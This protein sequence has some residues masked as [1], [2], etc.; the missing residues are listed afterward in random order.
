MLT[1]NTVD[2]IKS[3]PK[4]ELH[5]FQIRSIEERLKNQE[6]SED[7]ALNQAE[8]VIVDYLKSKQSIVDSISNGHKII[9]L[10]AIMGTGKSTYLIN[11]VINSDKSK[12]YL[13]VLKTLAECERYKG[14]IEAEIFE[15]QQ[16]GSKSK[17]L[18]RLISKCR[19]IVTT[20]S[21]IQ[22]IDHETMDLLKVAGYILIIDECLDV[23]HPFESNFKKSDLANLFDGGY[24][25][26]DEKG[27]M[28]WNYKDH[29][30]YNGRY[31]DV[32]RLCDL[33]SLMCLK[34][35]DG[36]LSNTV[37][38]WNFPVEFFELFER[39]Y[40]ATYLW[41]GSLQSAYFKLH[42]VDF[43]HM[44]LKDGKLDV[45]AAH[46]ELMK[47]KEYFDLIDIYTGNLNNIGS[48]EN[49]KQNPLTK[50][51]YQKKSRTEKG[52][53]YLEVLKNNTYNYFRHIVDSQSSENGYTTFKDYRTFIQGKG[54]SKGFI[55]CNAKGTNDFRNKTCLAYLINQYMHPNLLQ[56][57]EGFGVE[58]NQDLYS[59]SELL[60][61]IWRS[62]I[63]EGK[64]IHL[65]MPSQ[66][67]RTLLGMWAL[68]KL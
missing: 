5:N 19:N 45:Y 20:H 11:S 14:Q 66:R 17:D 25:T 42:N 33:H 23:V 10:D 56:F 15:P 59:V 6:I 65:Y 51:W 53:T 52:K 43:A 16:R 41:N 38:M 18:R 31:N 37:L 34:R 36:T 63:R 30:D 48:S 13:I 7:E 39:C 9:I 28:E 57:F 54:Y 21:L 44:T 1:G 22:N 2:E 40:V 29:E 8:K 47:R 61:W 67:M 35:Q 32:K 4:A 55:P 64:P 3:L 58:V 24:V 46:K 12:K 49:E 50:T 26:A 68:G 62:Q 60:Q 27:F